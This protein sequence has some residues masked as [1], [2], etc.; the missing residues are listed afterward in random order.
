MTWMQALLYF[1]KEA[2]LNLIRSW[3]VSLL[4]ILTITV[5]LFLTGVF[6]LVS[7][8]LRQLI[9]QWRGESKIVVY[10][11]DT[12]DRA[13]LEALAQSPTWVLELEQVSGDQ[14]HQRFREA[15]PSMSD[16]L[17]GWQ[18]N[19]LPASLEVRLAW[20]DVSP[21]AL[22]AWLSDLRAHPASMMVDDDRD[23]LGQLQTV[24]L[25]LEG[26]GLLVGGVLLVTAIF[27]ISSIIRLTAYL[28]R[29]EI[30][31][32]RMVGATEFFIRG[33]FYVEGLFQGL[34]GGT[35]STAGLFVAF[36]ALHQQSESLLTGVLANRFLGPGQLVMLILLGGAAGLV[37][38]V[39]SLR[40]ETL[41]PAAGEEES[42]E[43]DESLEDQ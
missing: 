18:E 17:E 24:V 35:L 28:Y 9:D 33:P 4:A 32:M 16:L 34:V 7:G 22:E 6:L 13:E 12:G 37:G 43:D 25:V 10:L 21:Q 42:W 15:F 19:P 30:A 23:W 29:D 8:N 38:A 3:K 11:E 39:A 2:S 31:V 20:D 27:T 5:S 36:S 1:G 41:G 14:A 26:F 40:R